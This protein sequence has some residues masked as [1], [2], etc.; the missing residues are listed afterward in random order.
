MRRS[1]AG[2]RRPWSGVALGAPWPPLVP[3]G[4]A[5]AQ[6]RRCLLPPLPPPAAPGSLETLSE[7][8]PA[9]PPPGCLVGSPAQTRL[10]AAMPPAEPGSGLVVQK[11]RRARRASWPPCTASWLSCRAPSSSW[12]LE[13]RLPAPSC[14]SCGRRTAGRQAS[15]RQRGATSPTCSCSWRLPAAPAALMRRRPPPLRQ[16]RKRRPP[17]RALPAAAASSTCGSW[18]RGRWQMR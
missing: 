9:L 17:W 2:Q 5:R 18:F 10:A 8:W 14:S 6:P 3:A 1:C 13:S 11:A 12:V 7:A 15:W 16:G 4:W